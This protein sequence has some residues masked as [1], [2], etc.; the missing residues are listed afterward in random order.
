MKIPSPFLAVAVT[1][2]C[3]FPPLTARVINSPLSG[4]LSPHGQVAGITAEEAGPPNEWALVK[5]ITESVEKLSSSHGKVAGIT[6]EETDPADEWAV[7]KG[8]AE[9]VEKLS[10]SIGNCS[11]ADPEATRSLAKTLEKLTAIL[12]SLRSAPRPTAPTSS[13][14][15]T[16]SDERSK[17]SEKNSPTTNGGTTTSSSRRVVTVVTGTTTVHVEPSKESEKKSPAWTVVLTQTP[18]MAT[19]TNV[20]TVPPTVTVWSTTSTITLPPTTTFVTTI[21]DPRDW[22]WPTT[23]TGS[24]GEWEWITTI[25][26]PVTDGSA[27][28]TGS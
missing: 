11:D 16:V 17:E 15:T 1:A 7:V 6:A 20:F 14:P 27:V 25:Y 9:S 13:N 10:S 24:D 4:D 3:L 23:R 12:E 18:P 5:N 19:V 22:I 8:L 26:E 21:R 2:G 28:P